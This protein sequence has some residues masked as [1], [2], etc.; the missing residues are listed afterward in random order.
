MQ[1][2][3]FI[4]DFLSPSVALANIEKVLNNMES[5]ISSTIKDRKRNLTEL[6]EKKRVIS[7]HIKDKRNEVTALLDHLEENL[8]QN[9]STL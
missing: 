4:E 6:R 9:A 1:E 5:N 7:E 8:Q 2:I 3:I